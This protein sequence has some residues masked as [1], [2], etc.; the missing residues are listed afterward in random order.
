MVM[1]LLLN[2]GESILVERYTYSHAIENVINFRGC[3]T[4]R[5]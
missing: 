2:R 3:V 5:A 4:L 1:S